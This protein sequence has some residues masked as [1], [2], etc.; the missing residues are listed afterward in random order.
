MW[1]HEE[2]VEA[3]T[4]AGGHGVHVGGFSVRDGHAVLTVSLDNLLKVPPTVPQTFY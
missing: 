4:S 2:A 1:V 3:R